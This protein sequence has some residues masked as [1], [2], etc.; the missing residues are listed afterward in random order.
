MSSPPLPHLA[1][2]GA[3]ITSLTLSIR[4][5]ALA[6]PHTIYEQ[7][8]SLTE[9]GAGLGFG[10]NAV[11]AL[12][13]I[14]PR[15]VEIFNKTATFVG[16]PSH[17]GKE[18]LVQEGKGVDERVWIEFLDG[19][20]QGRGETLEP[21]FVITA[22]NGRGHAAVHRGQWLDVLGGLA[23]KERIMFGKRVVDVVCLDGKMRIV[24]A[25]GTEA[26]ADGVVGC[27]GVKSKVREV[28]MGMLGDGRER[29]KCGYSGKYAYRCLVPWGKA[30]E[31]VGDDRAGVSSLWMGLNRHL[32]TFPVHRQ[33]EQF[34]NLV[35][36]VTDEDGQMW[37]QEGPA[38][39]TLPATKADALRDF[40]Q[41]GFSGS[42]RRLLEM[43]KERMDKWGL[44][45]VAD[46]P[47]SKF[48][49]GR[50]MVIGD[51]AHAS[52]PHHGSGAGFC[53][54]DIAVLGALF[55]ESIAHQ[56]LTVETLEDVFAAFDYQRR[57]RDQWLVKS[58]RRAA[59]LYQWRIPDFLEPNSFEK[60][61]ADIEQRQE[62]CWGFDVEAAVR[63]AKK[64]MSE[65][66]TLHTQS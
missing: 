57:E 23:D 31:A 39:L 63:E 32:L 52:T 64:H 9:L 46:R 16:T 13:Y 8:A 43:T 24:F 1:L 53:M 49:F 10:P 35:A 62:H 12:E 58:S 41:A 59:D 25:D 47:L 60:M 22:G 7:S 33:S 6:I 42:V 55:E 45:D 14:D 66:L 2:I 17:Q 11:R 30:V 27:D 3:G 28:L 61:K 36:F 56:S 51:A 38:S 18:L 26:G 54:E 44:Y 19:T 34:L 29:G 37:P 48:Y 20:K 4:L 65:R 15:L 5:S 50:I 21:E 40:E